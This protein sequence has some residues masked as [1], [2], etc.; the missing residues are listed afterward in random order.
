MV[1]TILDREGR[2]LRL[3][4]K[5]LELLGGEEEQ[6]RHQLWSSYF[7]QH[8][9]DQEAAAERIRRLLSGEVRELSGALSRLED[10]NGEVHWLEWR[11]RRLTDSQGQA[12][13]V[14]VAGTDVTSLILT[15]KDLQLTRYSIDH[16][17][18]LMYWVERSGRI[19]YY[20]QAARELVEREG[21]NR[22]EYAWEVDG[23]LTAESWED[24]WRQA[25]KGGGMTR[26]TRLWRPDGQALAVEMT[27]D[28]LEFDERALLFVYAR[29][30]GERKAAEGALARHREMLEA[31]VRS[32]TEELEGK[33]QLLQAQIAE[34]RLMEESLRENGIYVRALFD[35]VQDG[36]MVVDPDSL[37]IGEANAAC[38]ALL[39]LERDALPEADLG[40]AWRLE[41][42]SRERIPAADWQELLQRA[43]A[44]E[45]GKIPLAVRRQGDA[46]LLRLELRARR[47]TIH[48]RERCLVLVQDV[49]EVFA[50]EEERRRLA[51]VAGSTHNTLMILNREGVIE[52]INQGFTALSGYTLE[53]VQGREPAQLLSGPETDRAA[54]SRFHQCLAEGRRTREELAVYCKSGRPAWL[55]LEVQPILGEGD[56][57]VQFAVLGTDV[58]ERRLAQQA[59][60]EAAARSLE[61]AQAKSNF[62]ANMSHE[63]RT[64]L[65][66]V[67]GML[68]L[69]EETALDAEQRD[70][71]ATAVQAAN[72][73]TSLLSDILDL[74][75]VEADKLKLREE[76]FS[77]T[78][79]KESVLALFQTM[80]WKKG[81]KLLCTLDDR[82]PALVVGDEARL[83]QILFNLVGNAIKFTEQGEVRV[84]VFALPEASPSV[85]RGL[86]VVSDTGVGISDTDLRHIFEPFVQAEGSYN[87]QGQGVGLG[88]AIVRKLVALMGGSLTI[89]NGPEGGGTAFYL[90][91][92]LVKAS[93]ADQEEATVD[94][95]HPAFPARTGRILIVDDDKVS[96]DM[97]K[98]WLDTAGHATATAANGQEALDLLHRQAFDLVLMDIQMPVMNG[99][100][101]V[102]AMR[103][104]DLPWG[105]A[106]IPVIAMSA[107]AMAGDREAFLAAGMNTSIAKPLDLRALLGLISRALVPPEAS[108]PDGPGPTA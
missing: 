68:Q 46:Q 26:E 54:Q 37:A 4:R 108:S 10:R 31:T 73:L 74:S 93:L 35:G 6:A 15:L 22:R 20:N 95:A 84:E 21:Q 103:T 30:I 92:P 55:D 63:I 85:A 88:L 97:V 19:V 105:N 78:S 33:N 61:L 48:G 40:R 71:L 77:L 7:F 100:E 59:M 8:G 41:P 101:A 5:G 76:L 65:N 25:G 34:R 13:G 82:L 28:Y 94:A 32:R 51:L 89:D 39:G 12:Q 104:A 98:R 50:K 9:E 87:R 57:V 58:T 67:L 1:I 106:R 69:L 49:S 56:R 91:L 99:I 80:A 64:P 107:Y 60:E 75:R 36:V 45:A 42:D 11:C 16:A 66:G 79:I 3:N 70:C 38:V 96:L 81:L 27:V 72:R 53:D 17:R 62:L 83:R 24:F 2:I 23:E 102:R 18:E 14:V 47:V 86:F 29:D 90:A 43:L 44:P 52:W